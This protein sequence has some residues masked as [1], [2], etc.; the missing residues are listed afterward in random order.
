M[1][2]VHFYE[3]KPFEYSLSCARDSDGRN[4][5]PKIYNEDIIE[6]SNLC[7]K[8]FEGNEFIKSVSK[9]FNREKLLFYYWKRVRD[10]IEHRIIFLNMIE[11]YCRVND[12]SINDVIFHIS[13]DQFSEIL[14]KFA[15]QK[16]GIKC[17]TKFF[18]RKFLGRICYSIKPFLDITKEIMK[19][20]LTKIQVKLR[21]Q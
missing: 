4:Y 14:I 12:I 11:W 8:I 2:K 10:R 18:I 9:H 3:N 16:Y 6:F 7:K 19:W 21:L 20:I 15:K 1:S 13:K 17:E 5:Y